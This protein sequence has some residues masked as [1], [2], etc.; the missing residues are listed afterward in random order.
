MT[1]IE[2]E[3]STVTVTLNGDD[4]KESLRLID[5]YKLLGYS[6]VVNH[7]HGTGF[8]AQI[9]TKNSHLEATE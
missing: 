4:I 9:F 6:V 7:E 3:K 5:D 8:C 2:N 1:A